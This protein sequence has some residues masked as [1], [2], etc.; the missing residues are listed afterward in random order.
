MVDVAAEL[1][2]NT[3]ILLPTDLSLS[4]TLYYKA[5]KSEKDTIQLAVVMRS[6]PPSFD[7]VTIVQGNSLWIQGLMYTG[8]FS[9]GSESHQVGLCILTLHPVI[10]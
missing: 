7:L 10:T 6:H 3:T 9:Y 4:Q 1:H 5:I 8:T 2:N